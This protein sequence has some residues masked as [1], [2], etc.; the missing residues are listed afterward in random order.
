M[1]E[2][3]EI[4]EHEQPWRPFDAWLDSSLDTVLGRFGVGEVSA[5]ERA[6]LV[7]GW[8]RMPV[9]PEVPEAFARL[10]ERFF[11]AP[12]TVLGLAP[13][14]FSS[15]AAGIVWDAIISCDA[16]G[17]TKTDPESYARALEV[18][19]R[20]AERVCFV[21]AHPIDLRGAAAHGMRTAYTVARLHDYGDDYEDTGFADEFDVVAADFT[22]LADAI[23]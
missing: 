19:G 14:A 7:G 6:W 2:C 12:H 11:I 5:E 16:L 8:S 23:A 4:A 9:W 22:E 15:K 17:A 3:Y 20:P 10:R 18:I 21:A 1:I 13:V